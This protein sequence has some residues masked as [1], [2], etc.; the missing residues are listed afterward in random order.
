MTLTTLYWGGKVL[1]L[2]GQTPPAEALLVRDGRVVK[3]GSRRE[4]EELAGAGAPRVDLQGATLM[5]G[6]IDT[7]PHLLHFGGLTHHLVDLTDARSHADIVERIRLRAK[8][9]RRITSSVGP[10]VTSKSGSCRIEVFWTVQRKNTRS[11]SRPGL[12]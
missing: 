5:P 7:H 10:G 4:T 8:T 11:S 2:D 12:R 6:L 9:T 1:V 3:A